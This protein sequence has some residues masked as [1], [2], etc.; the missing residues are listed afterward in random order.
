MPIGFRSW[1]DTGITWDAIEGV[2]V[3]K[4]QRR[5]GH[6]DIATT[7]AYVKEPRTAQAPRPRLPCCRTTS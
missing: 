7:L 3:A 5:A 2:D 6:D 4:L 1:R